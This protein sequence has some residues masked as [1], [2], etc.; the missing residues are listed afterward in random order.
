[1][2][3]QHKFVNRIN[4][5]RSSCIDSVQH[6][7]SLSSFTLSL[8]SYVGRIYVCVVPAQCHASVVLL[9]APAVPRSSH[10]ISHQGALSFPLH[11][12]MTTGIVVTRRYLGPEATTTTTS[13]AFIHSTS[14]TP[15]LLHALS[16]VIRAVSY[17]HTQGLP[18][19]I[20]TNRVRYI[21]MCNGWVK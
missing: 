21:F 16:V 19:S 3:F 2:C 6:S 8:A 7:L 5:H 10:V 4:G 15:V 12:G 18:I 13:T 20:A 9:R 17:I 14:F 11:L 1:M